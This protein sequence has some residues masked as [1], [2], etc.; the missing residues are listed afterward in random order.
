MRLIEFFAKK[1]E[2]A[3]QADDLHQFLA[4]APDIRMNRVLIVA[5]SIGLNEWGEPTAANKRVVKHAVRM[6]KAFS[7]SAYAPVCDLMFCTGKNQPVP[8]SSASV[9]AKYAYTL[10]GDLALTYEDRK[11]IIPDDRSIDTPG[12]AREAVNYPLCNYP[13]GS[14]VGIG[15]VAQSFHMRRSLLC[16]NQAIRLRRRILRKDLQNMT[17]RAFALPGPFSEF[18]LDKRYYERTPGQPWLNSPGQYLLYEM[19]AYAY[20]YL[21]PGVSKSAPKPS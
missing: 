17:I 1:W 10:S 5:N 13:M 8:G 18:A 20:C 21:R 15:V 14:R 7:R 2:M 19:L 16:V 9:M 3:S 4:S 11:H 6:Y 12:N